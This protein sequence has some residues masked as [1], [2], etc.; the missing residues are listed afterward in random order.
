MSDVASLVSR[1]PGKAMLWYAERVGP[2][3]SRCYGYRTVWRAVNAGLVRT[4]SGAG[5]AR[6]L[7]PMGVQS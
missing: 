1:N 7:Y 3:G 4:E 6:V 2:H 5:N